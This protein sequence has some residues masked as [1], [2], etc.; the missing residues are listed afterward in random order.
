M[1]EKTNGNT[2]F[3]VINF[4]DGGW[5]MV[6]SDNN[7]VP[8]LGY[9]LF[10]T[11]K[12]EDP[13]PEAFLDWIN[14]YKKQ[15]TYASKLKTKS[16]AILEKWEK[17]L[18]KSKTKS[19]LT[20]TPGTPLLD[21]PNRGHV[22]WSQDRNNDGGCVPSYHKYCPS[23]TGEYCFCNKKSVGCGAVAMGQIMWYWQWPYSSSYRTYNWSSMPAELK[24]SSSTNEED[25]IAHLLRDCGSASNMTYWC[26][27]SWTTMNNIVD[28]FKNS[29]N[30]K[31]VKKQVRSKWSYGNAWEDLLRSEI[32]AGRPILY[33]G[34]KCDLCSEKHYFVLD[35][36]DANDPDYF[37][38][39][40]GCGV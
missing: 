8:V 39:N 14:G 30:Y 31:G 2:S 9:S 5:V 38:F 10:G 24:N 22:Q 17:L 37:W 19:T 29:F 4:K 27:G 13:K 21:V 25:E 28:A 26:S 3:Y 16:P 36:Y 7:T 15:I 20:Y 34:D 18:H 23:G 12:I 33:R 32:D 6:S 35:G 40:F 1:I 11:Y